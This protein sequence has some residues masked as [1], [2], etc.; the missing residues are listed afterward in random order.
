MSC[1]PGNLRLVD[2]KDPENNSFDPGAVLESKEF[3]VNKAEQ[4][5][6]LQL[7]TPRTAGISEGGA[8]GEEEDSSLGKCLASDRKSVV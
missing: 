6:N 8:Q 3:E 5:I 7:E 1:S 4:V 2:P